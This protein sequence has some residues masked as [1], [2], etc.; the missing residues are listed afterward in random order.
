MLTRRCEELEQK[1]VKPENP[2]ILKDKLLK[3]IPDLQAIK[4]GKN[5]TLMFSDDVGSTI[6]NA[7]LDDMDDDAVK[8][9]RAAQIVQKEIFKTN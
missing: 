4:I 6:K 2:T 8:L 1:E 3:Y 7:F 5:V 9:F